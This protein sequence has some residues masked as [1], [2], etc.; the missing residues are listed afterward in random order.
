[1][2]EDFTTIREY[3]RY[4]IA[5]VVLGDL[6]VDDES[7]NFAIQEVDKNKNEYKRDHPGVT[8]FDIEEVRSFLVDLLK[9]HPLKFVLVKR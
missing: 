3:E 6:N 9:V 2:I 7:I 4:N 5:H 8:D 1:M